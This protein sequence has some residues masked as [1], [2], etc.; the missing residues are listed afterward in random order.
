MNNRLRTGHINSFYINAGAGYFDEVLIKRFFE[1]SNKKTMDKSEIVEKGIIKDV[2]GFAMN[3]TYYQKL[4]FLSDPG[5]FSYEE[6]STKKRS[7]E[8]SSPPQMHIPKLDTTHLEK[9]RL[10]VMLTGIEGLAESG[11]YDIASKMGLQIY[12]SDD[13]FNEKHKG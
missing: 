7:S 2:L 10:Y 11:I 5:V 6:C 8:L 4:H 9:E 13:K 3:L 1:F 12:S